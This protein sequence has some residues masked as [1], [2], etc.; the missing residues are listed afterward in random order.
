[1]IKE[2][3]KLNIILLI[4]LTGSAITL[5]LKRDEVENGD[6]YITKFIQ[7]SSINSVRISR[8]NGLYM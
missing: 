3:V 7:L 1:M 4:L 2:H 6:Y 5:V 8:K